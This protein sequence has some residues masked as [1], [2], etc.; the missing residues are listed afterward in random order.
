MLIHAS[1]VA[2]GGQGVLIAGPSGAG[3]SDIALRLIDGGAQMVTDDQTELRLE[4]DSLLALPPPAIAGL[5]EIR[6]LGLVKMPF[7]PQA[8]VKL[9]VELT[10]LDE[11][12]ERLPEVDLCYLLDHP[13]RRIR[14]PGFA[15]STPAKIRA[16]LAYPLVTDT[17]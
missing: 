16:A 4:K 7:T 1:C 9:Y 5:M 14:L 8:R 2:I 11:K 17:A 10:P 6:H 3:K 15:A 13:V 12:L